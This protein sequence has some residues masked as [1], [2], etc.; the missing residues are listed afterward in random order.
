[1]FWGSHMRL[2]PGLAAVLTLLVIACG[3]GGGG[4]GSAASSLAAPGQLAVAETNIDEITLTW[5]APSGSFDGYELEGRIGSDSFQ[6]LHTGLIPSNYIGLILTFT[7]TA[8]DN[9]TYAFRLRTAKGTTFSAYSNEAAYSRGPN[10]PGQAVASFSSTSGAVSL[11]WDR[12]TTGSDGLLTERATCDQNGYSTGTWL[13]LPTVD[14]IA[15]TYVD[16]GVSLNLY[17]T[18]RLTN[19]KGTRAGHSS[20]PS[21]PLY[22][23][24]I[25]VSW[26]SA[27]YD[28]TLAGVQL[29]WNSFPSTTADGVLLERSDCDVSGLSLGN[30]TSLTVP[31]G[32]RTTFLDLTVVEGGR[33]AYRVSNLYGSTASTPCQSSYSVSI[34]ML[35]PVNLQVIAT[36]GGLQLTWQNR[37]TS[38]NQVVVRR[39][40]AP[41]YT[42]DIAILSPST[43]SYLDPV[44]S[45]GYYTYTVV[46]KN[47]TQEAS[48]ASASAATLNPPGALVLSATPLNLPF[49]PDA[50]L[51]PAGN[52]AF[53]TTYPFGVLSNNDPWPAIF[54]GNAGVTTD[55]IVQVDRQGRPHA[56]YATSAAASGGTSTLFHIW[57][58]GS[59][60]QS[61][62]IASATL[63]TLFQ[64]QGFTYRLDSTGSPHFL[65]DHVT[66]Q[67]P[68]GGST[69]SLSYIHKIG[70]AW[71]EEPL[72]VLTPAINFYVGTYHLRLD[73]LDTP[74]LLIGAQWALTDYARSGPGNWTTTS[75]PTGLSTPNTGS[76]NFVDSLWIDGNHGWVFYESGISSDPIL[77]VLQMKD[78]VWL[79]PQPLGSRTFDGGANLNQARCA[80]S[81]DG[82]RIAILYST[83]MGFK[84]FHQM[85]DGWHE[86]LVASPTAG[87]TWTMRLGFDANQTAHILLSTGSGYTDMHE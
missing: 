45:L 43:S 31:A 34:P 36:T 56:V 81:P 17:Y 80:L 44:T 79:P 74:H 68:Y 65:L 5:A 59:A 52:W 19:L 40:P 63:P 11:A 69:G 18:Y 78:G 77:T 4:N 27:Y 70:G 2:K 39:V 26:V 66:A 54:P 24:L 82:S 48:S 10:A 61:E 42:S 6:K 60:W 16:A 35:P 32:Y 29:S 25:S 46:A 21:L 76:Y 9:T 73:N 38:A 28:P 71:V 49:A 13:A 41:G 87:W 1:M 22:T 20:A 57:F 85:P 55:P 62:S 47:S 67:F 33:Y 84:T 83:S 53:A 14:P 64:A 8:P 72:D 12:N 30:W 58:D 50:A 86:T 15:A 3:G 23:G 7:T 75:L 37:S 51:R